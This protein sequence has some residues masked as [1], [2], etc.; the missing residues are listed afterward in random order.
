MRRAV[1][2]AVTGTRKAAVGDAC[3]VTQPPV[4]EPHAI[5]SSRP[6]TA[7]LMDSFNL[8]SG[9]R[10]WS[11]VIAVIIVGAVAMPARSKVVASA[12][13]EFRVLAASKGNVIRVLIANR[14]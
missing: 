8:P 6:V 1:V 12:G 13:R 11:S 5:P 2:A 9:A 10:C 7:R 14:Q 3:C 4:A